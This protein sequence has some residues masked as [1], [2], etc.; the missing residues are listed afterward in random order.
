MSKP[1]TTKVMAVYAIATVGLVAFN[2]ERTVSSLDL[3]NKF[4]SIKREYANAVALDQQASRAKMEIRSLKLLELKYDWEIKSLLT[5]QDL[6][7]FDSSEL[8]SEQ[9]TIICM[10]D[11]DRGMFRILTNKTE[12]LEAVYQVK[13]QVTNLHPPKIEKEK[14]KRQFV[15]PLRN[16]T[17]NK[18]GIVLNGRGET[19][20]VSVIDDEIEIVDSM[21]EYS[22]VGI[23]GEPEILFYGNLSSDSDSDNDVVIPAKLI[24]LVPAD[25]NTAELLRIDITIRKARNSD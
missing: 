8:L 21:P 24:P 22:I 17:W 2:V 23:S 25:P 5:S 7:L 3:E 11:S 6:S 20:V 14:D 1:I 19:P 18:L 15:F 10:T 9:T 16:N 12:N 13:R 4:V